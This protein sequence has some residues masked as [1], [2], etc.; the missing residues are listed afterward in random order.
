MHS[1]LPLGRRIEAPARYWPEA[2]VAIPRQQGRAELN[3][4]ELPFQG[5]DRWLAWEF[6]WQSE[7]AGRRVGVLDIAV[8]ANSAA[9]FE[10][11][12]LKLYL[13]SCFYQRF[14]DA[15]ALLAELQQ[16]LGDI[17][18][19][20]VSLR[21]RELGEVSGDL[22]IK[23]P[24][25]ICLDQLAATSG[26][27][28]LPQIDTPTPEQR[29]LY[30]THLFRSLCPVTGQPDWASIFVEVQGVTLNQQMLL[31]YLLGYADHQ[32]FHENCVERIFVDIWRQAKPEALAVTARFTRRGG[33]E[34]N[35]Y[36][37]SSVE[38]PERNWRQLRQ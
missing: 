9:I 36:R 27:P 11:K 25:G 34:I 4:T 18:D 29:T 32:G 16:R 5:L 21:Y 31:D 38:L 12:S 30:W 7:Q 22:H 24:Q 10:S 35:P 15:S 13:N 6:A 33:I 8:P 14:A 17:C 20:P 1:E 28:G 2:L 26:P 19:A 37:T 23:H 3:L